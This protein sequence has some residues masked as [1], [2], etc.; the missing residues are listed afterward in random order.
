MVIVVD[1][2]VFLALVS[3]PLRLRPLVLSGRGRGVLR[4]FDRTVWFTDHRR[5]PKV[6]RSC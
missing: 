2:R 1:G 5:N 4:V 3:A 6:S